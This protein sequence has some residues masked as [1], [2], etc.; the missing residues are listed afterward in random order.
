MT[1]EVVSRPFD[2][3]I[4]YHKAAEQWGWKKSFFFFLEIIWL[5]FDSSFKFCSFDWMNEINERWQHSIKRNSRGSGRHRVSPEWNGQVSCVWQWSWFRLTIVV[6]SHYSETPI[7][8]KSK[9][10][11]KTCPT[12]LWLARLHYLLWIRWLVKYCQGQSQSEGRF[13]MKN[14]W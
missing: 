5:N 11:K 14:V 1:L 6:T 13:F 10:K 3:K 7:V 8:R 2:K 9:K 4:S 12:S